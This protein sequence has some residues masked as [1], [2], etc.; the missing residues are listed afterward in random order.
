MSADA[1]AARSPITWPLLGIALLLA[2]NA[3]FDVAARG[4]SA[5]F[6]QGGFLHVG[7]HDGAP[8]G[9]L[10]DV[11]NHSGKTLLL[12]LGM[13][14][15]VAVRG[16]DLSAGSIMAVAGAVAATRIEAG[17]P[18]LVAIGL[19]LA[20]AAALGAWNALLVIG[21]GL[22]PFV[23]TLVLMVAGRGL[24]QW[25]TDSRIATFHDATLEWIGNG[26]P[27]GIPAPF[28][29]AVLAWIAIGLLV[30]K[31]ALRMLLEAVGGNPE[32]A[33][34]SGVRAS[35]LVA[36]TYIASGLLAGIAG[37]VVTANIKGADPFHAGQNAEL[38][39]IFAVV[40]GGTSLAGGRFSLGGAAVGAVF[41]QTLTT[42]LYA[43]DVPA[44]VAPLPQAL[45]ILLVCILASPVTRSW[46][47]RRAFA[48]RGSA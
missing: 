39:A 6:A 34:L 21:L 24:A 5:P 12:A 46:F 26:R 41:L 2:T 14:L 30:H 27:F 20:C 32:A 40:V 29:L 37:L 13:T 28:V 17:S 36:G 11:L 38:A 35:T 33:R 9:A 8:I 7:W 22:Q 3:A 18:A 42:T 44:D 48:A 4:W 15:V 31:T 47:A 19:A 45:V 16:I 1:S 43:R 10:V 23:A 25:I